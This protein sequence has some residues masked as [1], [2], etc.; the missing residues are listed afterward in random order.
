MR[1]VSMS[2]LARWAGSI[3]QLHLPCP[4]VC[5]HHP[6][7]HRCGLRALLLYEMALEPATLVR[8]A[9]IA[10]KAVK[11]T[12]DDVLK[13]VTPE[14]LQT[15]RQQAQ[16]MVS[17]LDLAILKAKP[18]HY[19]RASVEEAID[20]FSHYRFRQMTGL[21]DHNLCPLLEKYVKKAVQADQPT[22]ALDM[23]VPILGFR[24]CD[25]IR[26]S[27]SSRQASCLEKYGCRNP[28]WNAQCQSHSRTQFD[29]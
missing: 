14:A 16:L 3:T 5:S 2:Q 18:F 9:E 13:N 17:I 19:S 6:L 4:L 25:K 15:L 20:R 11:E 1:G 29:T 10:C 8:N 12:T 28:R 21:C 7:C 26:T 22:I 27:T 23:L 24:I